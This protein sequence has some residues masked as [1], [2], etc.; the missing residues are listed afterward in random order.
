MSNNNY[1]PL[2]PPVPYTQFEY[3]FPPAFPADQLGLQLQPP[4]SADAPSAIAPSNTDLFSASEHTHLLGFLDQFEWQF[5]PLLP[6]GLPT[7]SPGTVHAPNP[8]PSPAVVTP[9]SVQQQQRPVQPSHSFSSHTRSSS[10]SSIPQHPHHAQ[11]GG[12][13]YM[14][15]VPA[16]GPS[17]S[18]TLS[19][20]PTSAYSNPHNSLNHMNHQQPQQQPVTKIEDFTDDGN[21]KLPDYLLGGGGASSLSNAPR[22]SYASTSSDDGQPQP[23]LIGGDAAS[24]P[25]ISGVSNNSSTGG[26]QN[27][28]GNLSSSTRPQKPVLTTPE[29]RVRHILSEQRR[30]NTIRDGYTQL[31]TMLAPHP[32]AS[33]RPTPSK[34]RGG[35][36]RSST[37]GTGAGGRPK[38]ARGRTRGKGKSGVLFRAVEYVLW[39]EEG[40]QDLQAEVAKLEAAVQAQG[41]IGAVN[42]SRSG[43][44]RLWQP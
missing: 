30:R 27:G 19:A 38:G 17:Y 32:S 40:V 2:H 39:L 26:G 44:G 14:S 23:I 25:M 18:Q 12:P 15:A 35:N 7:F 29:K 33:A 42:G 20:S 36:S 11:I 34:T 1:S 10:S 9:D 3:S 13:V 41:T 28:G 21:A 37:N 4:A 22:P 31:T 5:D 6:H 43:E 24:M 8:G 16:T